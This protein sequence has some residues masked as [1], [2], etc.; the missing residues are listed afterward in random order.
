MTDLNN[1]LQALDACCR[2]LN[3]PY[4]IKKGFK[5]WSYKIDVC[6]VIVGN[7]SFS[8]H[9]DDCMRKV[10]KETVLYLVKTYSV[11]S[12]IKEELDKNKKDEIE[13][14]QGLS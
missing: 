9:G 2:T 4:V 10:I 7:K 13:S 14:L 12:D 5:R 11:F 1:A 8:S 6:T 3:M